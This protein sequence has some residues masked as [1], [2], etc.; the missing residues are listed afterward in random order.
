[1]GYGQSSSPFDS[2]RSFIKRGG[3]PVSY[4]LIGIVIVSFLVDWFWPLVPASNDHPTPLAYLIFDSSKLLVRPWTLLTYPLV[5]LAGGGYPFVFLVINCIFLWFTGG[6]LERAWGSG[7]YL[8]AFALFSVI[9]ALSL[10]LGCLLLHT[11]T[12][13]ISCCLYPLSALTIIFC[14]LNSEQGMCVYGLFTVR[15]KYIAMVIP[16]W[17]YFTAGLGA[18]LDIFALGGCLAAYLYYKF[19]RSYSYLDYG[20]R[21]RP[22]AGPDLRIFNTRGKR[23]YRSEGY[24]DGSPKP[25]S[26]F[27]I[28]AQLKYRKEQHKLEEF[29]RK[30]GLEDN[31]FRDS[32]SDNKR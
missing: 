11:R 15:A 28:P 26:I 22:D 10:E 30:S 20:Y 25:P 3:I 1:M 32:D 13:I 19:G 2:V 12:I 18:V 17:L 21:G 5:S 29:F 6:S 23:T 24:P 7:K 4:S 8:G 31:D 14:L 27:N 16:I 9:S